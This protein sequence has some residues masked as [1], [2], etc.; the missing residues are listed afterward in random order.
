MKCFK[1]RKDK[2]IKPFFVICVILTCS[3]LF[4][5]VGFSALSTSLSIDGSASFTPVGLIRVMSIK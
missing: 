3:L 5:T 2:R 4:I 1:R